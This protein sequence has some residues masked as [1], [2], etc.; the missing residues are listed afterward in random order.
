MKT[1]VIVL[2]WNGKSDTLNCLQS[3]TSVSTPH[4][5]IVV[6]NGSTDGSQVAIAEKFPHVHLIETKENL[7]YAEG[8]NM[9]IRYALENGADYIFI[10]NNDTRVSSE[11]IESFLKRD[12]PIQ[13]GKA[14]LMDEPTKID[15]LGGNWDKKK[16]EF[17]LVAEFDPSSNWDTPVTLDYVCGVALFV[18]AEVFKK[19]G[20]FDPRFFLFWEEA[21]WC[22]RAKRAG[23]DSQTCPEALLFHKRSASF[24]GGKPHTTYFWWRNRLLWIEKNCSEKEKK[25]LKAMI[26]KSTLKT[27]KSLCIKSLLL[28]FSNNRDK[29]R[30]RLRISKAQLIGVIHYYSRRFGNCPSS[31]VKTK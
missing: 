23:Y 7:G 20:L 29:R 17:N 10:L 24:T 31:L 4:Q 15:H 27:L 9:G 30:E 19:I 21:D 25:N 13:G 3:L 1:Y 14:L 16:G 26:S 22:L 5:T 11:I 2:N 18:K 12:V 28:P 6:D 8:N